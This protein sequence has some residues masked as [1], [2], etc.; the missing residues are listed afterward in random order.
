MIFKTGLGFDIHRL[1]SGR[2]LFLGGVAIPFPR[3]LAGHSD[4][5]CLIHAIIDSLLGACG[6]E[7][8][9]HQFPDSDPQ[10]K[11]RRSL[12]LLKDTM[13]KLE[14]KKVVIV[15]IDTVVLAERPKLA[16]YIPKMKKSLCPILKLA[17]E[18]LAIKAKTYEG[19]G[20]IGRGEAIAC[21]AQALIRIEGED[22]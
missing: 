16:P 22:S 1:Q 14:A 2:K 3:G 17:E 18:D 15:N 19:L 21:W 9:G 8:I 6:E 7:D 4:G 20:E 10:Y 12:D 5:D 13:I 11:D